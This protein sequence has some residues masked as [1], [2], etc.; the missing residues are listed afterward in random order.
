[1]NASSLLSHVS[2][3]YTAIRAFSWGGTIGTLGGLIGLGGA[4]FRLP[5]LVS[6]FGFQPLDAIVMNKAIS[7]VVV[8]AAMLFRFRVIPPGET[9]AHMDLVLNVLAGSLLGSWFA[10]GHAMRL[11]GPKLNRLVLVL[12]SLLAVAMLAEGVLDIRGDGHRLLADPFLQVIA[13]VVAGLVIGAVAALL[14]VAGGELLIPMFVLLYG[15]DIRL[16]GSLSLAV[17]LPTMIVGLIRY[18][19]ADAFTIISREKC[20]FT[21]MSLGSIGGAALGGLLL[22]VVSAQA[23]TLLLAVVLAISAA[24]VFRRA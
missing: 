5:V 20:L 23:L 24:K 9:L 6:R 14:G 15:V 16:A 17:S 2:R 13:G 8:C 19:T 7:L 21:W 10:A 18:R 11:A 4:E 22:D 12:L 3:P 1:M